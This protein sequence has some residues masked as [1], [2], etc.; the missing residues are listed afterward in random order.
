[1]E[2]LPSGAGVV[3]SAK[4]RQERSKD[5]VFDGAAL[6]YQGFRV[7]ATP[8]CLVVAS[9]AAGCGKSAR[10]Q[11]GLEGPSDA[12]AGVGGTSARAGSGG[13]FTGGEAGTISVGGAGADVFAACRDN[14][15]FVSVSGDLPAGFGASAVLD[16]GCP[17]LVVGAYPWPS[18]FSRPPPEAPG[19]DIHVEACTSDER[20]KVVLSVQFS[21]QGWNRAVIVFYVD[22]TIHQS[23]S[24]TVNETGTPLEHWPY[25][26]EP[27]EGIGAFYEGSFDDS[28]F[29]DGG[30]GSV[31]GSFSVC[32]VAN[33]P[34]GR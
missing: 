27:S 24:L 28:A 18:S 32:H 31:F 2:G 7:R 23:V 15:N 20:L 29:V 1:M 4:A 33:V 34:F 22:N 9:F 16:A 12:G 21:T 14:S 19:M 6:R 5:P 17:D 13:A 30:A 3:N 26:V 25:P 10:H 8:V 11:S